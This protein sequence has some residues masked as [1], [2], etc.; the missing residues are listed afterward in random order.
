VVAAMRELGAQYLRYGYRRILVYLERRGTAM[1]PDRAHRIWRGAGLQVPRRRPRR[2]IAANRPRPL[3]ASGANHVWAYDF[4]HDAC[5]N[6]QALK[7]LTLIEAK[8]SASVRISEPEQASRRETVE[9][10]FQ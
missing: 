7:C 1:S 10:L 5:A 3:P 4:L 8:P 9:G 6:G 2:R